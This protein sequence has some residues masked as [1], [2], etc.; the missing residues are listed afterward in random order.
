MG[1]RIESEGIVTDY[2]PDKACCLKIRSGDFTAEC[3]M[4]FESVG[5]GTKF[6][7]SG[8]YDPGLFKLFKMIVKRKVNQQMEKDLLKLKHILENGGKTKL[9]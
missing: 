8:I 1:K 6:T 7:A 5:D 2:E 4:V 3:N 9:H